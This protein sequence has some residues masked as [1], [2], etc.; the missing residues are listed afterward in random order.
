MAARVAIV[1]YGVGNLF[2]VSRACE[3]AGME[4]VLTS[5][6]ET[7]RG[8]AAVVLPGIGAFGD[9]MAALNR[10]GLV[11]C[12]RR[13]PESGRPLVGVCLGMQLLMERSEE[14]GT[15]EGLG[16]IE[17]TVERLEPGSGWKVPHV[18][19]SAIR[20]RTS[21]ASPA[22]C[23]LLTGT[24]ND[25]SMYFVHSYVVKPRDPNVIVATANYGR[26]QFSAAISVGSIWGVQFHPERSGPAGLQL[27]RNLASMLG[28]R[29]EE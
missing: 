10:L 23:A 14:F 8:S 29:P 28:D 4:P 24:P 6:A 12:L 7:V 1:D 11:D 26:Q 25:A 18:G 3:I 9:A 16:L 20:E 27:Y 5:D 13:L 21:P 17:G 15:H 19:W 2:S 22:P